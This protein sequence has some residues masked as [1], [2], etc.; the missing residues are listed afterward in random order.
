V[1]ILDQLTK[2]L[3]VNI[4]DGNIV[5]TSL[6]GDFIRIILVYN[7]GAAF[8]FGVN[9]APV[10]HF[11]LLKIFPLALIIGFLPVYFKVNFTP[12]ERYL[13]AAVIGGGL[14]NLID[15]FFRSNGVVDFIDVKFYGLF[16]LE[17]WPTFNVAD[18]VVVV[19]FS[20]MILYTFFKKNEN[21]VHEKDKN[22]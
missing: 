9:F 8:S 4:A 21:A 20:I 17:R 7:T 16:G 1:I 14:G 5:I 18:S 22:K 3:I 6:F 12:L 13:I 11:I 19:S 15:R 10:L 2:M